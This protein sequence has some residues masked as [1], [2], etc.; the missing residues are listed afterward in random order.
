MDRAYVLAL[1]LAACG[2]ADEVNE[3][4]KNTPSAP[5][6]APMRDVDERERGAGLFDPGSCPVIGEAY[7]ADDER[8]WFCSAPENRWQKLPCSKFPNA[9]LCDGWRCK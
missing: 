7:C 9:E 6:G 1:T 4:M 5:A 2:G 8:Y 3:V